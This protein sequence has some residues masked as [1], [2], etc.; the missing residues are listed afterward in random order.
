MLIILVIQSMNNRVF[1]NID[2]AV[3]VDI[4]TVRP[5]YN[6]YLCLTE[7]IK[8]YGC[9]QHLNPM[10]R[11]SNMTKFSSL[12]WKWVMNQLSSECCRTWRSLSVSSVYTWKYL[13][14]CKWIVNERAFILLEV[15]I[16]RFVQAK[17]KGCLK[18]QWDW[19]LSFF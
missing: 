15:K 16:M 3:G 14:K 2:C 19:K 1:C 8:L 13:C 10:K 5:S 11:S 17:K 7:W 18:H 9:M 12:P 6:C 4:T